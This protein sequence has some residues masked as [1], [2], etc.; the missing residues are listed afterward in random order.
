M[1]ILRN[2][3]VEKCNEEN[4]SCL[5]FHYPEVT[6]MSSLVNRQLYKH[7]PLIMD[8]FYQNG[9]TLDMLFCNLLFPL[10]N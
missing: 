4:Q 5:E 7:T 8:I 1:I 10:W 9:K 2:W 6:T 3:I